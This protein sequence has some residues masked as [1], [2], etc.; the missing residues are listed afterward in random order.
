MKKTIVAATALM[1]YANGA[2][3]GQTFVEVPVMNSVPIQE[4]S[5]IRTP[6]QS[7]TEQLVEVDRR[8]NIISTL[9]GAAI[10]GLMGS[11]YE[12]EVCMR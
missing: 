11:L 9:A 12:G 4:T 2:N 1:L 7:C 8:G 10:G 6:V 3:A 5:E